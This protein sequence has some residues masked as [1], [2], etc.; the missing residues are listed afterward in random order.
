MEDWRLRD[1]ESGWEPT[2]HLRF[3]VAEGKY[4]LQQQWRKLETG[5]TEW[6]FVPVTVD[7]KK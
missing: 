1:D 3:V 7:I 5:A 4:L 2:H 6:R